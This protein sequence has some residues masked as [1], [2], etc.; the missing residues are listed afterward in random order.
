MVG[1]NIYLVFFKLNYIESYYKCKE[2]EYGKIEIFFI[3]EIRKNIVSIFF[4]YYIIDKK[5]PSLF[6]DDYNLR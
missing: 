5:F 3:E 2:E 6:N 4:S 1:G